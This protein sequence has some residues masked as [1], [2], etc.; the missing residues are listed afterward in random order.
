[1]T[2]VFFH[3]WPMELYWWESTK[4]Y[5]EDMVSPP[6]VNQKKSASVSAFCDAFG[7]SELSFALPD[8]ENQLVCSG[9]LPR[10]F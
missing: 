9:S 4:R 3:S 6:Q 1:M 5:G 8:P 10:Q 2:L 7:V